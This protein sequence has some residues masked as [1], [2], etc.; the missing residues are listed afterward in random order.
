VNGRK[1]KALE[2]QTV[3][4][5]SDIA[6]LG[7]VMEWGRPLLHFVSLEL[8]LSKVLSRQ[9]NPKSLPDV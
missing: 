9:V 4:E 3:D 6:I 5:L 1:L 8:S 7:M 2:E